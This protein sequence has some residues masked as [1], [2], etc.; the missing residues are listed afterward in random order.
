MTTWSPV[1]GSTA[2]WTFEPPVSTPTRRMQANAASRIAWYSTSVSVWAGATVIESP[3]WMPIG[4]TFSIEQMITQLSARSRITS[5]SNSFHPAIDRSMRISLIGLAS[6]P[7]PARCSNSSGV[8][9]MPVPLP[10]RMNA[11]RITTGKARRRRRPRSSPRPSCG[12]VPES[13][14]LRPISIIACLNSSRSSA[15]RIVSARRR[16][17]RS[18]ARSSAPE[19]DRS[20]ARLSAVCP[21]SVGERRRRVAPGRGSR[22]STSGDE[23]LDVGGVG[24]VGVGHDRRRVRVG[25]DHP[26]ALLAEHAARLGPRVVEL[27]RLADDDRAGADDEDRLD[28]VCAA[29]GGAPV[30]VWDATG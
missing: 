6:S 17:A 7:G 2:N 28:V 20:M 14:T 16:S 9:A 23:R 13:G 11:G 27:A 26:V 15:V 30:Q 19:L 24:E 5:S 25:E 18:P 21:P 1:S 8:D 4:S 3:V 29:S 22:S 10:P 12:A